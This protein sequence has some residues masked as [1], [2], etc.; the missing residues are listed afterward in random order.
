MALKLTILSLLALCVV[1]SH[2]FTAPSTHSKRTTTAFI[3]KTTSTSL[4]LNIPRINLPEAVGNALESIDLQN[5]N[6]LSTE[7]YNAYS[8]VVILGTLDFFLL[9]GAV[10][11]ALESIDL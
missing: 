2:S 11:N 10:G 3:P 7:D 1:H 4:N 9:P 6:K 5:P 8:G